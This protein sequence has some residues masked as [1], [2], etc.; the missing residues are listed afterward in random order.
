MCWVSDMKNLL[1]FLL[2]L[3]TYNAFGQ[4]AENLVWEWHND[5][6]NFSRQLLDVDVFW[7]VCCIS[8][9]KGEQSDKGT[10]GSV[11]IA[12]LDHRRPRLLISRSYSGVIVST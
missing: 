7:R 11:R 8:L 12:T 10:S 3:I 1:L 9:A 5:I 6:L 2:V 4:S